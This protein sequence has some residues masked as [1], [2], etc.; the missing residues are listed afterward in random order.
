VKKT[1]KREV[2]ML[3]VLKDKSVVKMIEAFKRKG[4]LYLVFEFMDRNLLEVLEEK[5]DGL[6]RES[7]KFFI[8]QLLKAVDYFH[9]QN[10]MHRDIKPENL[11]ICSKTNE[12][13]VCDFGFARHI[14]T[15]SNIDRIHSSSNQSSNGENE[16][17]NG[18]PELTDYV[19][20]RWYRSP[21][22]LL[23]SSN[24]PYGKE[25][26]IWAIGCIMGELMDGQPLFPGDSEVD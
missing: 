4:R 8:Y 2:K 10:V 23:V 26:D 21:E 14:S 20:T 24:L 15:K 19:A 6:D 13:K 1:T 3:N 18:T 22:L 11:L 17:A 16:H 7:V 9:S 5:P 25:V 12:L